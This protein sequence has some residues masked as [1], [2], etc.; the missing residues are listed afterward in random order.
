MKPTKEQTITALVECIAHWTR[1]ER[2][3]GIY[4][5]NGHRCNAGN[6]ALCMLFSYRELDCRNCPLCI[7]AGGKCCDYNNV[8]TDRSGMWVQ[9]QHR[10]VDKSVMINALNRALTMVKEADDE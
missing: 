7:M 10:G 2:V 5:D 3:D 6:C 1:A 8:E 9:V 4:C